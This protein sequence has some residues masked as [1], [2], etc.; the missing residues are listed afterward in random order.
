MGTNLLCQKPQQESLDTT[1]VLERGAHRKLCVK[2]ALCACP[3]LEHLL[4]TSAGDKA[5]HETVLCPVCCYLIL[6][7]PSWVFSVSGL[8][9]TLLGWLVL[10]IWLAME[11]YYPLNAPTKKDRCTSVMNCHSVHL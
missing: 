1:S 7:Q 10:C 8:V 2:P 9:P 11:S 5:V 4:F 6:V 3:V